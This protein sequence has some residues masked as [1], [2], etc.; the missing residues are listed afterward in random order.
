MTLGQHRYHHARGWKY[1]EYRNR[2][3][4]PMLREVYAPSLWD[5]MVMA[6]QRAWTWWRT[7]R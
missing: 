4:C 5:R 6:L 7:P 2:Y 1:V 3:G